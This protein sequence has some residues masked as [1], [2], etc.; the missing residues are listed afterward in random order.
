MAFA[1]MYA[2]AKAARIESFSTST[3][4]SSRCRLDLGWRAVPQMIGSPVPVL[5]ELLVVVV[6]HLAGLVTPRLWSCTVDGQVSGFWFWSEV[7]VRLTSSSGLSSL[8]GGG[9]GTRRSCRASWSWSMPSSGSSDRGPGPGPC[10]TRGTSPSSAPGRTRASPSPHAPVCRRPHIWRQYVAALSGNWCARRRLRYVCSPAGRPLHG[11]VPGSRAP[12]LALREAQTLRSPLWKKPGMSRP[13]PPS[14]REARR[15]ATIAA[16]AGLGGA[17]VMAGRTLWSPPQGDLRE[18]GV[19]HRRTTHS[20]SRTSL[21]GRPWGP[22]IF[23]RA[24]C[25]RDG[26]GAGFRGV[27]GACLS[28]CRSSPRGLRCP[29]GG[30]VDRAGVLAVSVTASEEPCVSTLWR[31]GARIRDPPSPPDMAIE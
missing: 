5:L 13:S 29:R 26:P 12:V 15:S 19:V 22:G 7:A 25:P 17:S 2:M 20:E 4:S 31:A 14:P 8:T 24:L 9:T 23:R 3:W 6:V 10:G 16:S 27:A 28:T 21:G 1:A 30:G 11:Q 18:G